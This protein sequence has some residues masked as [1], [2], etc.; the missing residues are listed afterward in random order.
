[1]A[2]KDITKVLYNGQIKLDY[3]DKAHRY[4][5][6]PRVEWS[7]PVE[8][9]KAWGKIMYPKGTTTL[10]GD[11]LEKK[12]LMTWPLGLA[13]RELFGF[14][15]FKT[16]EGKQMTGFS[17]G[18]GTMWDDGKTLSIDQ[19]TLLPIVKS[20]N[21][22]WKR[23]QKKGADIGSVVHDAIEHFI[24][25]EEFDI[26]EAYNW[27]IKESEFESEALRDK[28]W[29][30]APLEVEQAKQAFLQFQKW[31]LTV[32]PTLHSA[33]DILYSLE[34]NV[35]GTYDGDISIEGRY[36]P[37][38]KDMEQV[39]ICADWKTSNA[40][41]SKEAAA[42]EGV[43]YSY[44]IQLAIYEMMRREMGFPPADDLLT[45]SA[46]KD[47]SFSL[48]YAS[49]LGLDVEECIDWAK[50]VILCYNLA[51]K[52]K[53]ALREHAEPTIDATKEAF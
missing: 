42:P 51:D 16:D 49:E 41:S 14:Y 22:A 52:T 34:H 17:K 35:C 24:K 29:E 39:R 27:T 11:T 36:H 23:K 37:V 9:P 25:E 28:A 10:I 6:R 2:F 47:G 48:V 53:K 8:D 50:A 5:A 43:Y 21:D 46:R 15:D 13:I 12:G 7:L 18:V 1:M 31:W 38:Y 40:S 45:V 26:A 20:A 19:D 33:E 44:F 4:Y 3:K 32:K 30:E